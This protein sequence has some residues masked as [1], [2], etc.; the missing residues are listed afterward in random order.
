MRDP[1]PSTRAFTILELLT[2]LALAAIVVSSILGILRFLAVAD[3]AGAARLDSTID[4]SIAQRALSRAMQ[5]L[6]AAPP[7]VEIPPPPPV[8]DPLA[9]GAEGEEALPEADALDHAAFIQDIIATAGIDPASLTGDSALAGLVNLE[10]DS[11]EPMMFELYFAES[12]SGA[13]LPTL[14]LVML[15]PPIMAPPDQELDDAFH[16]GVAETLDLGDE[17]AQ[18]QSFE[19]QYAPTYRGAF[20]VVE[21]EAG[22]AFQYTPITPPDRPVVLV[23]HV[24]LVEMYVLPRKGQGYEEGW[25][26]LFAA[27]QLLQFPVAVRIVLQTA[28]GQQVDWV[29]E[30]AI[31]VEGTQ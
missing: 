5:T 4:L 23:P 31:M 3:R 27:Q 26:D 10:L 12:E 25:K 6:V 20:E 7:P 18:T 8:E 22:W 9:E 21:Y 17:E 11:A 13:G 15:E 24:R 30:T 1:R 19:D 28:D 14:E 16:Q 29:F 2:A